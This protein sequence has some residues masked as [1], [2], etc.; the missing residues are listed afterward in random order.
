MTGPAAASTPTAPLGAL[1]GPAIAAPSARAGQP[2]GV[3]QFP[4][5]YF[6]ENGRGKYGHCDAPPRTDVVIHVDFIFRPDQDWCVKPGVTDLGP[7]AI[8][9]WYIGQLCDAG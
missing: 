9:A 5:G 6:W 7:N 2:V 1:A 3:Q 4:C 8:N